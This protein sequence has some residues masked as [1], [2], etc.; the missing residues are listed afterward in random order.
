MWHV[1]ERGGNLM[2][3]PEGKRPIGRPGLGWE[4]NIKMEVR[5]VRWEHGLD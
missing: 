5:E 1:W 2:E 4:S 3:I